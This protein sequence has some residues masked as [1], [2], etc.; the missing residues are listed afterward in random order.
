MS[1]IYA[2]TNTGMNALFGRP[3]QGLQN[4][5]KNDVQRFVSN[6]LHTAGNLANI[7]KDK[8]YDFTLGE[9]ARRIDSIR[10]GFNHLWETDTVKHLSNTSALQQ[11]KGTMRRFVMAQPELRK[12]YYQN[13]VEGYGDNYIDCSPDEI[14]LRHYDYR[15]ITNGIPLP[16]MVN[17][18][19]HYIARQFI[20]P[21]REEFELT[22]NNK[23]AIKHTH[24]TIAKLLTSSELDPTSEHNA[25]LG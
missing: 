15:L 20:E 24:E 2:D 22:L 4:M 9:T 11:A 6:T 8:L 25:L 1:V 16:E 21:E 12:L 23:A 14:G 17:G 3:S 13:R 5:L 18:K 10:S 19:K 7:A